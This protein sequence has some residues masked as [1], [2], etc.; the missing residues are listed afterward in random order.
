M[1]FRSE[2][3]LAVNR[4]IAVVG[5]RE[6]TALI[7]EGGR[8]SL[9]GSRSMRVFHYG[10]EPRESQSGENVSSILKA[11]RVLTPPER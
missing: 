9:V 1:L 2:E 3:F 7:V 4:E 6:G 11:D 5:L 8:I 10:R